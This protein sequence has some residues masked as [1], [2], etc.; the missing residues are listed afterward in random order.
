MA[1]APL[2]AVVEGLLAKM[3]EP[4]G[5]DRWQIKLVFGPGDDPA[6]CAAMPEYRTATI[7][8]DP[9][10]LETGDEV[11][12]TLAH[13]LTH[14]PLWPIASAADDLVLMVVDLVPE[15][16]Q[17]GMARYLKEQV[18]KAEED[19]ATQLGRGFV[20]LFRRLWA[21]EAELK[22]SRDEVRALRRAAR[23]VAA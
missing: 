13:E 1:D 6:C 3:R 10:K 4:M 20:T 18:R 23:D 2:A 19:S 12:E 9:D 21:A 14:C 8:V 16:A 7:H 11:D 17:A 22:A 15:S 5:L